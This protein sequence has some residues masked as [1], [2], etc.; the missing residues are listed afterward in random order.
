VLESSSTSHTGQNGG[1]VLF[2]FE[3]VDKDPVLITTVIYCLL[4]RKRT[5]LL[6]LINNRSNIL[7]L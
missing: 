5:G 4:V 3:L 2:Q 6:T 1:V 7:Q